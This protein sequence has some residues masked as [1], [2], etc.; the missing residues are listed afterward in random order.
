MPNI[1]LSE[2][3][4]VTVSSLITGS[5]VPVINEKSELTDSIGTT[6]LPAIGGSLGTTIKDKA[7]AY[8]T[9][10]EGHPVYAAWSYGIGTVACF[11]RDLNGT[12]SAE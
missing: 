11:T 9:T 8:I 5:F 3:E 7:T 10:D 6:Q 4:Q 1:M 2:A 12:W